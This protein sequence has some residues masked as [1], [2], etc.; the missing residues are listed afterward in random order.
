MADDAVAAA[1]LA[2][3]Q[4]RRLG[5]VRKA[6]LEIGGMSIIERQIAVLREV[7]NPVFIVAADATPYAHLGIDVVPD[8]VP[9]SGA[10]VG[11]YTAILAA[12][13]ERTLVVA[14][15]MPFLTVPFLRRLVAVTDADVVVPRTEHGFEPLCAV[16]SR[17]CAEPIRSRLARGA[18]H[19]SVLPEGVRVH[20]I[21]PDVL[22]A[23]DA[24]RLLFVNVNTPHDYERARKLA[25][26][27]SKAPQDRIM[28]DSST[29]PRGKRAAGSP[30]A[31]DDP[32]NG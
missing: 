28:D 20:E 4:A 32:K 27:A 5:G 7:A 17:R 8:A 30:A 21:D 9:E 11:I 26:S 15:D 18:L 22:A 13:R 1:I 10:L 25:E 24:D 12:P 6:T 14:C 23:Y 2:G 29:P 31:R 3:G 19:A 16:Y